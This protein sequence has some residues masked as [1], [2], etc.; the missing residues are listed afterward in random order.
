MATLGIDIGCISVKIAVVGGAED[1]D[2]FRADCGIVAALSRSR[3]RRNGSLPHPDS[4]PVLATKYRRI[5]GSPDRDH[6]GAPRPGPGRAARGS[7]H[8][9]GR[10]RH[11]RPPGR[12]PA[13]TPLRERVQGHRPGRRRAAPDVTTVFE[14]G[15]ETSKFIQSRDRRGLGPG[16]HRRLRHQRRLRRRHR[17]VHGPA[18]QPAA[19]R[20]R[21][22]GRHRAG[23]PARRPPSPGAA[24]SSPSRT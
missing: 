2:L 16:R 12:A 11:R 6:P 18:G 8:R 17:L 4:P 24:R 5:K 3:C 22:R 14:M 10:D 19:L 15:G 7:R 1:R 20:H 21:G 23:R 9:G 13:R